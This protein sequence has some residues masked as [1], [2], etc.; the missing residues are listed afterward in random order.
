MERLLPGLLDRP[1]VGTLARRAVALLAAG[2]LLLTHAIGPAFADAITDTAEGTKLWA[3]GIV[4]DP[5]TLGAADADGNLVLF[6]GGA[7]ESTLTREQ[8]FPGSTSG[9]V[10][11][12]AAAYGDQNTLIDMGHDAQ[13]TLQG[14]TSARGEA[15]R[16]IVQSPYNALPDLTGDPFLD[17]TR[18]L[19]DDVDELAAEFG[20]CTVETS[21]VPVI[22]TRRLPDLK[23]C[24]RF[25]AEPIRGFDCQ[26]THNVSIERRSVEVRVAVVTT[27]VGRISF[28]LRTGT[29]ADAGGAR[30]IWGEIPGGT[31][32]DGQT[33]IAGMVLARDGSAAPWGIESDPT[34]DVWV[35]QAPSAANGWTGIVTFDDDGRDRHDEQYGARITVWLNEVTE[36]SWGP[37]NCLGHA[38]EVA[39]GGN[40][41]G[42]ITPA[43]VDANG[44][45]TLD[46]LTICP[47]APVFGVI[48]PAPFAGSEA[49]IPRLASTAVVQGECVAYPCRIEN[50]G[51]TCP[52]D[53]DGFSQPCDVHADDP[54]CSFVSSQCIEDTRDAA[55]NC[56]IFDETWDCGR[57]VAV[58]S[59]APERE[60]ICTSSIRCLGGECADIE[61]EVNTSFAEAAAALKAT[62]LIA[63]D[64]A[65]DADTGQCELFK[66]EPYTCKRVYADIV[67][68][69]DEPTTVSLADYLQLTFAV[70]QA[71]GALAGLDGTDVLRGAWE[72]LDTVVTSSWDWISTNW[73]SSLNSATG[74]TTPATSA[75]QA[76]GILAGA[77]NSLMQA[78]AEW[79]AQ[80]FGATAANALFTFTPAT[81]G[82]AAGPA[83][84]AGGEMAGATAAGTYALNGPLI[85]AAGT[86]LAVVGYV[87]LV[88]QITIMLIQIV[89]ACEDKEFELGVKKQLKQCNYIGSYCGTE[90]GV[91]CFEQVRSFCCFSSPLSRIIQEQARP[92]LGL[93]WGNNVEEPDCRG[94][95][96]AEVQNLDWS[97]INLD[98]W[99]AI[100]ASTGQLPNAAE[101]AN[102]TE[103]ELTGRLRA[104]NVANPDG[105][106]PSVTE[107]T[108]ERAGH[109]DFDGARHDAYDEL[110]PYATPGSNSPAVVRKTVPP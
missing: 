73:T 99:V 77:T 37:A 51:V 66:G 20:S 24:E 60:L 39:A 101:L 65:C 104:I 98:E 80:T 76:T 18:A 47:G 68:C 70:A 53:A 90:A 107:R 100:L 3:P 6:P 22:Q 87:Y 91:G 30:R 14:E 103:E 26:I 42:T 55:G 105:S 109:V 59:V 36:Q 48:A 8:L 94:L 34:F 46:G 58:G 86:V 62:Q 96:L 7:G 19:L 52:W 83:V 85:A 43:G 31:E 69:C 78:A 23:Q 54:Q 75:T 41:V 29:Y 2:S 17:P 82:A 45:G 72:G 25:A 27:D 12:F 67:N 16:T 38:Q 102:L 88:Y 40:C 15:Y 92:Q 95:D 33:V 35:S 13:A 57:D 50:G 44:C 63:M 1:A 49:V 32:L 9:T 89:W 21:Y 61:P 110:L 10:D 4:P 56:R 79:T 93:G 74:T 106:R 5:A 28:N 64:G 11:P 97:Q 71:G 108:V 81:A 84:T